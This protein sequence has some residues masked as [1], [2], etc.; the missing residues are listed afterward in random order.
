M[1]TGRSTGD[2]GIYE[3][4]AKA[5]SSNR[6]LNDRV[7][8]VS[9]GQDSPAQEHMHLS[10]QQRIHLNQMKSNKTY[11]KIDRRNSKTKGMWNV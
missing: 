7:L 2:D 6:S 4:H 9:R 11:Y 1:P 10:L 5:A 8:F 3:M